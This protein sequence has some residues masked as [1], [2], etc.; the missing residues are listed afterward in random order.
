[1][2]DRAA[3]EMA[4]RLQAMGVE[5]RSA[6]LRESS[7]RLRHFAENGN[8]DLRRRRDRAGRKRGKGVTR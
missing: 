8:R 2:D 7:V 5:V 6:E 3:L 1:M 4:D